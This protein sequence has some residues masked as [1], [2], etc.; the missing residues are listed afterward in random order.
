MLKTAQ[1]TLTEGV[2]N[3]A[4]GHPSLHMLPLREMEQAA[5]HRFAQGNAEFLQYGYEWGDG[6]LRTELAAYLTCEYGFPVSAEQTFISGGTSQAI[7]L[8]C[9]MLTRPGDT[10]IV[11]DPTYFFAFGMFRDHGLNIVTA[12]VDEQGLDV[13]AL[14]TLVAQHRPRLVYTIPVHQNPAGVTLPQERRE[15]LVRLAQEHGFTILADEVYQ[16]LTFEGTPPPSFAAW[17]DTGQ[18]VSLGSFSKIL[19]PGT[20]LG[21]INAREDVLERLAQNGALVSGGGYSPLGGGMVRSMLELG[22]L[23]EYIGKLRETF[24]RR[25]RALADA[26]DELRPLGLEFQRPT[27]GYFIWV[28]LPAGVSATEL[29][30]RALDHGVRFQPGPLFSPN[31]TQTD[32]ARLCFAFYEEAELVEGVRR[33]G[34]VLR[35]VR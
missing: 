11:E 13:D 20:R 16:L 4:V 15:Q 22:L 23:P 19:A 14:E 26:L 9:A 6:F 30:P 8:C 12:P 21:W 31:G 2:I 33:L 24:R 3:L 35:Q 18:V 7:D 27:G 10:V 1:T 25:S 29:L 28:T 32:K 17:A 34:E 5:A